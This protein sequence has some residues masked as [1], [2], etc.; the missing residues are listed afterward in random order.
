M[1]LFS[2]VLIPMGVMCVGMGINGVISVRRAQHAVPHFRSLPVSTASDIQA[3]A[4][5]A[6]V[7]VA[8]IVSASNPAQR[9]NLVLYAD[10][11]N[12]SESTFS[13]RNGRELKTVPLLLQTPDGVVRIANSGY[14]LVRPLV[15]WN[16]CNPR[17]QT[18]CRLC[19]RPAGDCA[20][21]YC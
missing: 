1:T 9:Y 11:I 13:G 19:S 3:A 12:E 14:A 5:G 2:I 7:V 18:V 10:Q 15:R 20:R 4:V 21:T 16:R 17:A 6:G 8:G